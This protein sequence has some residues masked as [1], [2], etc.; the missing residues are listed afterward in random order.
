MNLFRVIFSAEFTDY[1][2]IDHNAARDDEVIGSPT[3]GDASI[4]DDFIEANLCH[5]LHPFRGYPLTTVELKYPRTF[6]SR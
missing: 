1:E 5:E 6:R 4:S 2:A 3:G